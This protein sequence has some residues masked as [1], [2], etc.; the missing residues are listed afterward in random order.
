MP[1]PPDI[2]T[3][4]LDHFR[5]YCRLGIALSISLFT[6]F[7]I[8]FGFLGNLP[9]VL[10]SLIIIAIAV[11]AWDLVQLM[12][13]WPFIAFILLS[14]AAYNALL[15][16]TVGSGPEF[17][18]YFL[19]FLTL[20][21]VTR[22]RKLLV[23]ILMS[24]GIIGFFVAAD[25]WARSTVPLW[26]IDPGLVPLLR[27]LN[28]LG[29]CVFIAAIAYSDARTRERLSRSLLAMAG[30]DPLTGLLNRRRMEEFVTL[31]QNSHARHG[32]PFT[33]IL[34]DLDHFK[35]INDTHGH[36][37]GDQALRAA[38]QCLTSSV[39]AEDQVARWGGEEFL[40]LLPE[41]SLEA[42]L[43]AAERIRG[44]VSQVQ[45]SSEGI[46]IPLTMTLGVAQAGGH[47]S[48]TQ[49]L[50]RADEALYRGKASG[51]NRV[52]AG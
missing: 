48:F 42:G 47:T 39:R 51:R 19:A 1:P 31:I 22:K 52:E 30:T 16:R 15:L 26:P 6:C 45:L 23:K 32:R 46:P 50:G 35:A 5:S 29:F 4:L 9:M 3:L 12:R 36:G 27:S 18:I 24:A 25:H 43:E 17:H 49:A 37:A 44:R 28:F 40:I 38:A 13:P 41:T 8:I 7:L 21:P 14:T 20:D 2:P 10:A 11:W 34:G 33:V